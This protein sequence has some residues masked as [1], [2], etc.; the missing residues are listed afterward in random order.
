[1]NDPVIWRQADGETSMLIQPTDGG[2]VLIRFIGDPVVIAVL[3][4]DGAVAL[5]EVLAKTA[6]SPAPLPGPPLEVTTP[7][8]RPSAQVIKLQPEHIARGFPTAPPSL[9]QP[10]DW[11]DMDHLP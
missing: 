8:D 4:H 3:T 10:T 2:G 5:S 9:S 7:D 11:E 1:M 6:E